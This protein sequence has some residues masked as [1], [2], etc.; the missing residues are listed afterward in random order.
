MQHEVLRLLPSQA[1]GAD[2]R[3]PEGAPTPQVR[4]AP[5][6]STEHQ[7]AAAC[8]SG[9]RIEGSLLRTDGFGQLTEPLT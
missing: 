4:P 3:T 6:P 2:P 9:R 1:S 8:E 5:P 7:H